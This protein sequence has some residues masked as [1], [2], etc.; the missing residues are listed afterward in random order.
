M[1][2][3][4]QNNMPED[5]EP[6]VPAWMAKWPSSVKRLTTAV[7]ACQG[8]ITP[9]WQQWLDEALSANNSHAPTLLE[10]A[11]F[12]DAE[13]VNNTVA[14]AYWSNEGFDKWWAQ[15]TSRQWW[16]SPDRLHEGVGYWREIFHVPTERIETLHSAPSTHGIAAL[17]D[18]LE[19][20]VDE[21]GYSGAARDRI[22]L[23][24]VESLRGPEAVGALLTAECSDG[25]RRVKIVPPANMCVI[26]SGQDW[27]H[28]DAFERAFYLDEVEPSLV[29]GMTFLR[30]NSAET[31]CL[32][33][34]LMRTTDHNQQPLDQT[35]GLGY[36]LDIYAFEEWAKSHPTHLKILEKFMGHA[37]QFGD[38]MLLRLWHEVSVMTG[39]DGE[40]EY[41]E[42]NSSTGLLRYAKP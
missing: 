22:P 40:F 21:H 11:E 35:F 33:M 17:A 24:G 14:I 15:P 5:F 31:R 2:K 13:G 38:K 19:G 4:N 23:S 12:V 3:R 41:I 25:G 36:A 10:H 26:R 37:G 8:D 20:P 29:A 1:L 16:S 9:S 6:E 7:F 39:T 18:E 34:R 42:C 27:G 30:D 28:C 32:S